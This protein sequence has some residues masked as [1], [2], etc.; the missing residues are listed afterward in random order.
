[1][2]DYVIPCEVVAR[3]SVILDDMPSDIS[4]WFRTIRI[5]NG[6]AVVTNRTIMAVQHVGGPAGVV[7]LIVTPALLKA[8]RTEAQ[9]SSRLTITVVDELKFAT[10]KTT[11]G[12]IEASNCVRWSDEPNDFDRW[13]SIVDQLR[14]P[15][16]VARGGMFWKGETIARLAEASPSGRIVFETII[17]ASGRPTLVRDCT[18]SEWFGVFQPFERGQAVAAATLPTWMV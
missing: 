12:F 16:A 15:A 13:R 3:L 10:A 6:M 2:T 11:M 8:C 5:D 9:Y 4:D 7:H 1:M 17:D 18:D 14:T